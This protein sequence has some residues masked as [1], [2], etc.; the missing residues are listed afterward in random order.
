MAAEERPI[1]CFPYPEK[2]LPKRFSGY[3]IRT[4]RRLGMEGLRQR[5]C[6]ASYDS[7]LRKG[8][9]AIVAVFADRQ[10]WTVELRLTNDTETPLRIDQ[11]K[12]RYNGLPL[13]PS[14]SRYTRLWGLN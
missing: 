3:L 9:C 4:S 13:L 1:R 11:I 6:V 14:G 5:H 8:D 2:H 12:T 10:R 7:R